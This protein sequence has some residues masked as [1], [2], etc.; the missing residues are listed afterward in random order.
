M[1]LAIPVCM[2]GVI[3]VSRPTFIFGGSEAAISLIGVLVGLIQVRLHLDGREGM[4]WW[5]QS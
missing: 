1:F 5:L 3:L 4:E 2:L